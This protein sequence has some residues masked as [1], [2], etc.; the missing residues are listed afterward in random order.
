[1]SDVKA[2]CRALTQSG[3]RCKNNARPSS[4]FCSRHEGGLSPSTSDTTNDR[5]RE[6]RDARLARLLE[7]GAAL[8][9]IV[10]TAL[11]VFPNA[12]GYMQAATLP[13]GRRWLYPEVLHDLKSLAAA[14]AILDRSSLSE[15]DH[16]ALEDEAF[17][18]AAHNIALTYLAA[19][20]FLG[21]TRDNIKKM[22]PTR[23]RVN[24]LFIYRRSRRENLERRVLVDIH[25]TCRELPFIDELSPQDQPPKFT[26]LPTSDVSHN[27]NA[28]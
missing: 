25:F 1:M 28:T 5:A 9:I 21:L 23:G 15:L 19:N 12:I 10:E 27:G 26:S 8:L 2:K 13:K 16:E 4:I 22:A 11:R 7:V 24:M 3:Q 18:V 6:K 17:N 14:E 20:T